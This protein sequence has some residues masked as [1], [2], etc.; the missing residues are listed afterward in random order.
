TCRARAARRGRNG[1]PVPTPRS[2]PPDEVTWG[3]LRSVLDA[4]LAG[5]PEK[6]RLPLI[7]CYLEGRTQDEAA[8]HLGWG[9]NT[10]R[11]RLDEA[12]AALGRRL[13]R[14]GVLLPAALAAVLLSDWAASAAMSPGLVGSTVEAA[15]GVA[16]GQAATA[17]VSATVAAL[18]EGVWKAMLRQDKLKIVLAVLLAAVLIGVGVGTLAYQA[19]AGQQEAKGA[20]QNQPA[21]P[22]A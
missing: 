4:E 2:G 22:A 10:L 9:K 15:V 16:A 3:E 17:T 6:W 8:G 7:L 20:A 19:A 1:R 13:S 11:R 18:T 5:L 12:R 21:P 14:R